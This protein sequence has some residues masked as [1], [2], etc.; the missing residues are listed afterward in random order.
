M[1][2]HKKRDMIN[3]A[4]SAI[5]VQKIYDSTMLRQDSAGEGGLSWEFGALVPGPCS[6]W[7]CN[8]GVNI[9]PGV[10]SFL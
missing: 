3:S 8:D 2:Y 4:L 6:A 1:I 9:Q 5:D 10:T 7:T